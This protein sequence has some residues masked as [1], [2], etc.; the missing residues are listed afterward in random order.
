M[1]VKTPILDPH[2]I[3]IFAKLFREKKNSSMSGAK[4]TDEKL[5]VII[6]KMLVKCF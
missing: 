5:K 6:S 2:L 1:R 4:I 3:P